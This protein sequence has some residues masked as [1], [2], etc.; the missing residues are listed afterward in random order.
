MGRGVGMG[1]R[2]SHQAAA[3]ALLADGPRRDGAGG[4]QGRHFP[5]NHQEDLS[6][7]ALSAQVARRAASVVFASASV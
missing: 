6:V 5:H 1:R 2:L 3:V 7:A 4:G